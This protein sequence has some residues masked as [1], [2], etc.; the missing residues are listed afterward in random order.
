MKRLKEF[1]LAV[2]VVGALAAPCAALAAAPG[3]PASC[4]GQSLSFGATTFHEGVGD[5][6]SSAPQTNGASISAIAPT[7]TSCPS[8]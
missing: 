8:G 1:V 7:K 4:V 6:L 2:A 3:P 5:V